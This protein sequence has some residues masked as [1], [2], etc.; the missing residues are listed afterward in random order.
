MC[1]R[2]CTCVK[3]GQ[4]FNFQQHEE[5]AQRRKVLLGRVASHQAVWVEEV[6]DLDLYRK[7]QINMDLKMQP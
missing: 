7:I 1:A 6:E 4:Q 5:Q 2:M 3:T